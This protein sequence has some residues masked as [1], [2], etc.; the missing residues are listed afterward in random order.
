MATVVREQQLE[1]PPR[2]PKQE[3]P[4]EDALKR[5]WTDP[6]GRWGWTANVQN[7][8][9]VKRFFTL[10]FIFFLLGGVEAL[11]MRTQLAV[12]GNTLLTPDAYNQV[13][14]MHGSTIAARLAGISPGSAVAI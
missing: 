10:V 1:A 12:P 14:T 6:T 11:L 9:I 5:I 2:Q 13:F 8:P 3:Q 7:G 4:K